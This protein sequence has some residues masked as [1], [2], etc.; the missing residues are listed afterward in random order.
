MRNPSLRKTKMTV[1]HKKVTRFGRL[2]EA[3]LSEYKDD[4]DE[5]HERC[6]QML[7]ALFAEK[8]P[9]EANDALNTAVSKDQKTYEDFCIGFV[10]VILTAGPPGTDETNE[11]CTK[12]FRDL[13]LVSRDGLQ[14]ICCCDRFLKLL[15]LQYRRFSRLHDKLGSKL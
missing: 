2:F 6:F 9:K 14:V 8:S 7:T 1:E 12:Y 4:L 5:R 3:N 11:L 15:I 10:V 13:Q